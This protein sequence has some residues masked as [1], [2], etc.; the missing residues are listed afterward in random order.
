MAASLG[1]LDQRRPPFGLF[2]FLRDPR[3]LFVFDKPRSSRDW[4]SFTDGFLTVGFPVATRSALIHAT[5]ELL[6]HEAWKRQ[7]GKL[8]EA[9]H[10]WGVLAG[11]AIL[12]ELIAKGREHWFSKRRFGTDGLLDLLEGIDVPDY[13]LGN[14]YRGSANRDAVKHARAKAVRRAYD[15]HITLPTSRLQ[16]LRS[17]LPIQFERHPDFDK[18]AFSHRQIDYRIGMVYRYYGVG[19]PV[20][21]SGGSRSWRLYPWRLARLDFQ[22]EFYGDVRLAGLWWLPRK[23]F[24]PYLEHYKPPPRPPPYAV[25]KGWEEPDW[26]EPDSSSGEVLD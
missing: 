7:P 1:R 16:E 24:T 10:L 23:H 8:E 11:T 21:P 26:E 2:L 18:R 19:Q 5:L 15:Y 13:L 6:K 25:L 12:Q 22:L 20:T 9:E 17:S 14:N 4:Q 3:S